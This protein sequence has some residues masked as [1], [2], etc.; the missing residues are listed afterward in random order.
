MKRIIIL[1]SL[2]FA[3]SIG[4]S[5]I[6]DGYLLIKAPVSSKIFIGGQYKGTVPESSEIAFSLSPGTY[7]LTLK[8]EGYL[9]VNKKAVVESAKSSIVSFFPQKVNEFKSI[10]ETK[11]ASGMS[12]GT[13]D[14]ISVPYKNLR[15]DI[16]GYEI[17]SSDF[18]ALALVQGSYE[19]KVSMG[20]QY[21]KTSVNIE[22][23]KHTVLQADFFKKQIFNLYTIEFE[24]PK[25][26]KLFIDDK[27]LS[28][29]DKPVTVLDSRH[30]LKLENELYEPFE[31]EVVFDGSGVYKPFLIPIASYVV[32]NCNLNDA[33][34]FIDGTFIGTAPVIFESRM[35]LENSAVKVLK[36]GYSEYEKAGIKL[37]S[38]EIVYVQAQL[39]PQ[40]LAAVSKGSFRMG[41]MD[42]PDI[43]PVLDILFKYD[44]YINPYET[45]FEEY[46][47][48]CDLTSREKPSDNGWGRGK[49][50]VIN[51]SWWDAVAYCNWF[52][53]KE[54][55]PKAYDLWGNL[56]DEKGKITFDVKKVIGYR[57]PTQAE[58]EYAARGGQMSMSFIYSGSDSLE[59]CA[60]FRKNSF[61]MTHETGMKSPNELGLYDMSGNVREWCTDR[62]NSYSVLEKDDP[63]ENEGLGRVV[64]GGSFE[65]NEMFLRISNRWLK[66][67][68]YKDFS[69]GFRIV[70]TIQ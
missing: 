58:W 13:V 29:V 35:Q 5:N 16:N 41:N 17:G 18:Y 51:V 61:G 9:D 44:F 65:M 2:L 27:E 24:L 30:K 19:I 34:V 56:L 23:D 22:K 10:S 63:Y 40:A 52:S 4:L 21:L 69:T 20:G 45:T 36:N 3:F 67:Q 64:K 60:W 46:D 1:I 57:L 28:D 70:K 37:G 54:G 8:L 53:E 43:R 12:Y 66:D 50:P 49:R 33:Q 11:E 47:E 62:Y 15:I 48:F 55:L 7:E 59:S 31:Q 26:S 42:Y 39:V 32:V 6:Y 38:K 14:I 25:N 68:E